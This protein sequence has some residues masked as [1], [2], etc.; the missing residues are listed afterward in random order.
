ML[1]SPTA[2]MNLPASVKTLAAALMYL[3]KTELGIDTSI[4]STAKI[5][6]VL[7]KKLR[8]DLKE[9]NMRV[10]PRERDGKVMKMMPKLSHLHP[11]AAVRMKK[12]LLS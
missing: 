12:L 3:M 4:T 1:L 2:S 6:D 5:F 9:S 8:Q 11:V 7:E 10:A